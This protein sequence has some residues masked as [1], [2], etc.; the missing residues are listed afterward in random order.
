[1]ADLIDPPDALGDVLEPAPRC[2]FAAAGADLL[3][4]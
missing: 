2:E 3:Q 1:M 4:L